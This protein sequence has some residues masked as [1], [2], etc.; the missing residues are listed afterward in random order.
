MVDI[1]LLKS[2]IYLLMDF[3]SYLA[4]SRLSLVIGT[5][6]LEDR[7]HDLRYQRVGF[8]SQTV[9]DIQTSDVCLEYLKRHSNMDG[10]EIRRIV[11]NLESLGFNAFGQVSCVCVYVSHTVMYP[12][13]E[14]G[15]HV[16]MCL[17]NTHDMSFYKCRCIRDP[18]QTL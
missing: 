1:G 6:I 8:S 7:T 2:Q 13:A 17:L 18:V 4:A 5:S 16:E 15:S 10:E 11:R 14:S 9:A 12:A 3:K